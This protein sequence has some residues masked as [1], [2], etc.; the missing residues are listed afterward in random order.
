MKQSSEDNSHGLTPPPTPEEAGAPAVPEADA[1]PAPPAPQQA[2]AQVAPADH[3][4]GVPTPPAPQQMPAQVAP[5][6]QFAGVPA[7]QVQGSLSFTPMST[8]SKRRVKRTAIVVVAIVVLGLVGAVSLMFANWTR[9]PEAQVRQYLD[10]LADGKASAATA[11]VDPGLP[12]DQRGFLSDDVM[13]SAS[14]RLVVED[15]VADSTSGNVRIVTATMQLDGDRFT[16]SFRVSSAKPTMGFLKNW[17]I[18]DAL[19][20]RVLVTGEKVN[21]FSVGDVTSSL[22][23]SKYSSGTSFVFYPG[24]YTFTPVDTGEYVS[25]DP[26]KQPVKAGASDFLTNSSSATVELTGRYNDK[27]AQEALNAAVDLTNSCVTIPGNINKACPYAVQS[28]HLSVLELKSAPTSVKQDGPGSDTYIGEAVFS[29][30]SDSG[31]DKSPHD[32]EATVRVTVKLDSDGTIQL[33]SAGKPVFDVK[34]GF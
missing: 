20:T 9:T 25:A 19:V 22:D 14:A 29:I 18:E 34:F 33:D 32:E 7:P 4:A 23:G 1:V 21:R 28:K 15:V 31:F 8:A 5:T 27:L 17:K 3:F 24:V 13:A 11:M 30:Q 6:D 16:H 26:V 2:P 10:L 12:N